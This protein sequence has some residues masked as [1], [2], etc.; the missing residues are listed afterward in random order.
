MKTRTKNYI[1]YQKYLNSLSKTAQH[2]DKNGLFHQVFDHNIFH[3]VSIE[4]KN[5]EIFVDSLTC[6]QL[7][8]HN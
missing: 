1:V 7:I 4:R 5:I 8:G 2:R 3:H 6:V